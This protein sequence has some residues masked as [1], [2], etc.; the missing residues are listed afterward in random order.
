MQQI[1]RCARTL[2]QH[3][4]LVVTQ[5]LAAPDHAHV[6]RLGRLQQ[7]VEDL[8]VPG[9]VLK[10]VQYTQRVTVLRLHDHLEGRNYEL[11]TTEQLD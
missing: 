7:Q 10:R 3:D 8:R 1:E 4:L 6:E 9:N 2:R 11:E 5:V